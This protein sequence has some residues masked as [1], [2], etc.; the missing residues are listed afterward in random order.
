MVIDRSRR[1]APSSDCFGKALDLLSRRAHF[2][3][4][5][6]RKLESRG[7]A[8]EEVE[9]ALDRAAE[10]GFLNDLDC[11]RDFARSR[12]ERR[13][14]GPAR[15]L[16]ALGRKGAEA[17]VARQAVAECYPEGEGEHLERAARAW[18][19]RN[20]WH[21]DRLARHLN[22][23]GFSGGAILSLLERLAASGDAAG[24]GAR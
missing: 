20:E 22:G 6:E 9:S 4:E 3:R 17:E 13:H 5:L 15:L 21:H 23:K 12:V 16:A 18:L 19:R 2:R 14:E 10:R 7:Y 1:T 11:A 8:A 24:G